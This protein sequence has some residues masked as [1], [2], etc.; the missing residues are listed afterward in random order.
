MKLLRSALCGVLAALLLSSSAFAQSGGGFPSRPN[1]QSVKVQGQ[2]VLPAVRCSNPSG[3]CSV[4]TLGIG[5]SAIITQV[6]VSIAS[7]ATLTAS[8]IEFTGLPAGDYLLTLNVPISGGSGGAQIQFLTSGAGAGIGYFLAGAQLNTSSVA[9]FALINT[10]CIQGCTA[11]SSIAG[12][13]ISGNV[14]ST[15]S[16]NEL[17]L[18]WAQNSSNVSATLFCVSDCEALLTRVK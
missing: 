12:F 11:G 9:Q 3:G 5:Q 7:N 10:S 4:S 6:T 2:T 1:F 17:L 18:E 13:Q 14:T 15:G 16:S 8:P